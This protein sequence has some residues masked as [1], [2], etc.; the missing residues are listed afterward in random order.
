MDQK[1]GTE[2]GGAMAQNEEVGSLL[3]VSYITLQP[4]LYYFLLLV[5]VATLATPPRDAAP[6]RSRKAGGI[7]I[8]SSPLLG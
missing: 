2:L 1:L 5:V 6:R 7:S 8:L 4:P 3:F